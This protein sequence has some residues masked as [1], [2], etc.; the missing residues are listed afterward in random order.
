MGGGGVMT[1]IEDARAALAGFEAEKRF[2]VTEMR[3]YALTLA[4]ALR[5]LLAEHERLTAP[6]EH[7][8]DA[9]W[10]G[11]PSTARAIANAKA[12]ERLTAPPTDDD[13]EALIALIHDIRQRPVSTQM[14]EPF[15][16]AILAAGFR[17]ALSV[18]QRTVNIDR[19]WFERLKEAERRPEPIADA[20]VNAAWRAGAAVLGDHEPPDELD[21]R[22]LRAA[23]EAARAER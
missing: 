12:Q 9:L 17:R 22:A 11:T 20:Q 6:A 15:A 4:A 21:L 3:D 8:L 18:T 7:P 10:D 5:A 23:L 16:D 13:R 2:R 19:E 14:N 1:A